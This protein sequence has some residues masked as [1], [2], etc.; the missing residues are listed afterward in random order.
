MRLGKV[1]AFAYDIL[2]NY[3]LRLTY[4]YMFMPTYVGFL[5]R[6]LLS[7]E[8]ITVDNSKHCLPVT[9]ILFQQNR[10]E[11]PSLIYIQAFLKTSLDIRYKLFHF[12]EQDFVY[13]SNFSTFLIR[14]LLGKNYTAL[15][16]LVTI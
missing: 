13:F 3:K 2:E 4:L 12:Q 14:F 7:Y 9:Q 15:T 11:L 5:F 10:L 6:V 1:E 8:V 16:N